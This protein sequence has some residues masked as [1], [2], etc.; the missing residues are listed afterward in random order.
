[1]FVLT[2]SL[3][4]ILSTPLWVP[5]LFVSTAVKSS[6]VNG[7]L[8]NYVYALNGKDGSDSRLCRPLFSLT[9]ESNSG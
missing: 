5:S 7:T 9:Y 8:L 1:M 6:L 2:K 3:P 4:R